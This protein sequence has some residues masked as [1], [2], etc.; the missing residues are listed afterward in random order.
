MDQIYNNQ[1]KAQNQS[2]SS[3]SAWLPSWIPLT[4]KQQEPQYGRLDIKDTDDGDDMENQS[5]ITNVKKG[6]FSR[7]QQLQ[8][9]MSSKI[10][11]GSNMKLFSVFFIVGCLFLFISLTFL[12]LV[13]IAPNKFNLFFGMGSLFIQVSLAFYH[14]PLNYVKLL[15]KR[16]NLMISLLYVGSVFMAVYSA[17]IWGTYLSAI[18]VVVIQ[19]VSLAYFVMQTFQGGQTAQT[20]LQSMVFGG[21]VSNVFAKI[22]LKSAASQ[23]TNL[24]EL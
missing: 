18:L 11:T 14:G 21:L 7:T 24:F 6:I 5:L 9:T 2:N 20:K 12:P 4:K 10:G 23:G 16:E 19:I 1:L 17:L 22:G 15:F 8:D 3:L 13:L